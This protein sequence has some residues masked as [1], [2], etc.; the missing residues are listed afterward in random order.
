[1]HILD[2]EKT[3]TI[4]NDEKLLKSHEQFQQLINQ[5][6]AR[7]LSADSVKIINENISLINTSALAGNKLQILIK[8][9]QRVILKHLEKEYKL[10][11]KNYYRNLWMLFGFTAFGLPIG[12]CFG[13]ALDNIGLMGLGLPIGMVIGVI[14]GTQLDKRAQKDGKQLDLEIKY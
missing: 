10:T 13:L 5:I 7:E 11:T 8:K 4:L 6:R 12:V 14:V 3:S 2:I 1:M 9:Q